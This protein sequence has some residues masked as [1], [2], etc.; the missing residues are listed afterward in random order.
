MRRPISSSL[1]SRSCSISRSWLRRRSRARRLK[2]SAS[3]RNSRPWGTGTCTSRLPAPSASAPCVRDV[4]WRV[5]R[6]DSGRIPTSGHDTEPEAERQ[7]A[8]G[9]GA[10]LGE[11]GADRARDGDHDAGLGI[12]PLHHHPVA[13]V[14][15]RRGPARHEAEPLE[16]DLVRGIRRVGLSLGVPG[17]GNRTLPALGSR[18]DRAQQQAQ[19]VGFGRD[20]R[21]AARLL[22]G[23]LR[24]ALRPG[25]H[26]REPGLEL[27][28]H[29]VD[30]RRHLGGELA[31]LGLDRLPE[32]ALRAVPGVDGHA[33]ERYDRQQE[34]GD[35][36]LGPEPHP[37]CFRG[38]PITRASPAL[39]AAAALTALPPR[40]LRRASL[41]SPPP[42]ARSPGAKRRGES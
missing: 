9:G 42:R 39:A 33:Q 3:R 10:D 31:C 32:R 38:Q 25:L 28:G 21:L 36:E 8:R 4:R 7:V 30:A 1:R 2:V 12:G 26:A 18:Q 13:R 40:G 6:R 41:R 20:Q 29:D 22:V 23:A 35:G 27:V 24:A 17:E 16:Q 37:R 19:L 34:E 5:M 15:A 11:R 14:A